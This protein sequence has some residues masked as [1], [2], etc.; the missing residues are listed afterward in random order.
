[1]RGDGTDERRH[2]LA[3]RPRVRR[4]MGR[5]QR[6]WACSTR[7]AIDLTRN[8]YPLLPA[9]VPD[10]WAPQ[11]EWLPQRRPDPAAGERG[12]PGL[13]DGIA[14]GGLLAPRRHRRHGGRAAS[15][16]SEHLDRRAGG[17]RARRSHASI[18]SGRAESRRSTRARYSRR[19]R[20]QD[21]TVAS[22]LNA[23]GQRSQRHPPQPRRVVRRTRRATGA[24]RHNY[25][26]V[27]LRARHGVGIHARSTATCGRLLPRELLEPAV[28]LVAR[29]ST[30]WRPSPTTGRAAGIR[31]GNIRYQ[32][33]HSTGV[34]RKRHRALG[35]CPL[36]GGDVDL[37]RRDEPLRQRRALQVDL[38]DARRPASQPEPHARPGMAHAGGAALEHVARRGPGEGAGLRHQARERRRPSAAT[39][40]PTASPSRATCATASIATRIGAHHRAST[41]TSGSCGASRRAGRSS[42]PTTTTA[43]SVAPFTSIDRA[44]HSGRAS[45]AIPR[46]RAIFLNVRYEDHAGTPVAPLGG[47]PGT[48]AGTLVGYVYYDANDNGRARR[49]R[50]GRGQHHG[51]PRRPVRARAPTRTAASNS[52]CSPRGRTTSRSS[53]TTWRCP[54]P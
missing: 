46:D 31:T 49:Q 36:L 20:W 35:V 19:C 29:A 41:R 22:Q 7:P 43:A 17:R 11:T 37:R 1:M 16:R 54:T 12:P 2:D 8:Q 4:R 23:A 5:Q 27:P 26:A 32:M 9:D 48:G 15:P 47:A 50:A 10:R 51:R 38:V 13:Y 53:P 52:R 33:D 3:A 40:S 44:A 45:A 18:A 6:R 14:R 21:A 28:D 24:I 30:A 42:R 39:T 25:G 34:R